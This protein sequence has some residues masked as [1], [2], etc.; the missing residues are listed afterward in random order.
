MTEI[1]APLEP[2]GEYPP[3]ITPA[4]PH[5]RPYALPDADAL[6]GAEEAAAALNSRLQGLGPGVAARLGEDGRPLLSPPLRPARDHVDGPVSAPLTLVVFGAHGT[7]AS[8]TLG[9]VLAAVQQRH[10][11]AVRVAWR[12]YFHPAVDPRAAVFALAAEAAAAQGRF[13]VLT[14]ELL[15]LRHDDPVDLHAALLRAGLDPERTLDRMRAGFG[16]DR[17]AAD[18]ASAL[19]SGVAAPPA[20]FLGSHRYDGEP[21]AR[22]VSAALD[23]RVN[24]K[25]QTGGAIRS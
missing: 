8:R 19:A 21:T 18:A 25:S 3:P 1:P 13:W 5:R 11:A 9:E 4:R 16:S 24:R 12:H 17:I 2:L 7:P 6:Y 14:R 22:A 10:P 20:L 23:R 15:A